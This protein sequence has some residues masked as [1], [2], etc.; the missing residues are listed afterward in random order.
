MLNCV[1]GIIGSIWL[2]KFLDKYKCFKRLQIL[3][4]FAISFFIG[5]TFLGLQLDFPNWLVLMII[6]V[7]GAPMSSVSVVSY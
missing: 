3:N 4:A 6:V 1:A 2:G 7:S 5:L